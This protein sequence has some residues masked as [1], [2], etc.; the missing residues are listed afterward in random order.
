MG[1]GFCLS[2]P[3]GSCC[4]DCGTYV[5]INRLWLWFR[6][7]YLRKLPSTSP[8]TNVPYALHQAPRRQLLLALISELFMHSYHIADVK[9]H[10]SYIE[11]I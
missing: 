9:L 6:F 5:A 4:Q 10:Q 8:P 3:I 2:L 7:A 11:V 1:Y